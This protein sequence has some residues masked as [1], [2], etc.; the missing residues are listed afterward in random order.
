MTSTE[1]ELGI[2][3]VGL[4]SLNLMDVAPMDIP[5][6]VNSDPWPEP[7]EDGSAEE[8][9]G[10]GASRRKNARGRKEEYRRKAELR[11]KEKKE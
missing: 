3:V 1:E 11:K 9:R 10:Q 7:G 8:G 5:P 2:L 6:A 4:P